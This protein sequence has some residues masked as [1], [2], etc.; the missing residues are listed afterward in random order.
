MNS[1]R[2]LAIAFI[3][4]ALLASAGFAQ[5]INVLALGTGAMPVVE[6]PS[7]SGWPVANM[8]DDAP[9]SGWA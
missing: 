5:E 3:A 1:R 7:Y 9:S 4:T 6:P 2:S 8:L